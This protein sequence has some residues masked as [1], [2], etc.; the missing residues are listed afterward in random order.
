MSRILNL[1]VSAVCEMY[2]LWNLRN[3]S[4]WWVSEMILFCTVA[5]R[6]EDVDIFEE[7]QT[8]SIRGK[9]GKSGL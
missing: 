6:V 5:T 3:I 8:K 7:Q 1:M 4:L 2:A 9:S